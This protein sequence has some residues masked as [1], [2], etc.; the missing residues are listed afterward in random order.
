MGDENRFSQKTSPTRDVSTMDLR[1]KIEIAIR[2]HSNQQYQSLY[3]TKDEYL[4]GFRTDIVTNARK[5]FDYKIMVSRSHFKDIEKIRE[6]LA[7]V[8]CSGLS[9]NAIVENVQKIDPRVDDETYYSNVFG[10]IS[11]VLAK[12]KNDVTFTKMPVNDLIFIT[13]SNTPR[14]STPQLTLPAFVDVSNHTAANNSTDN[15]TAPVETDI[16][17]MQPLKTTK[18]N[19]SASFWKRLFACVR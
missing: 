16:V 12:E 17:Y 4:F 6:V 15:A 2:I 11:S 19:V 9:I 10:T 7:S 13:T 18:S 14:P 1:T 5:S 3:T 8:G